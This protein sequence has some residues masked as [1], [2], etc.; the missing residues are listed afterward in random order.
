MKDVLGL[1]RY[2]YFKRASHAV[3]KTVRVRTHE[4]CAHALTIKSKVQK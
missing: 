2:Q 3:Q 4:K 1:V